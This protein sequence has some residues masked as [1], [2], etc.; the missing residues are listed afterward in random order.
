M[1]LFL[2]KMAQCMAL[3]L[4]KYARFSQYCLYFSVAILILL[5]VTFTV[6]TFARPHFPLFQDSTTGKY[7]FFG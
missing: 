6:F 3:H 1:L 2:T 4:Y 5:A 7:G